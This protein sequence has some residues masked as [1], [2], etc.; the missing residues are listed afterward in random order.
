M[1]D[2]PLFQAIK[3]RLDEM[4]P[5]KRQKVIKAAIIGGIVAVVF[6]L[7]YGSGQDAKKPPPPPEVASVIELGDARLQDD[8]RAQFGKEREEQIAQNSRQDSENKELKVQ[9]AQQDAQMKAMQGILQNMSSN[10][11]LGLP[12]A[13]PLDGATGAPSADPLDWQNGELPPGA[14][15]PTGSTLGAG[16]PPVAG[17]HGGPPVP[18]TVDFIGAVGREQGVKQQPNGE[19]SKKKNRRFYLPPSFMSAKLLTGLAAKTVDNAKSDPE[20]MMLRVQAPAVLP[21]EVRAQLEGCLIV[22]HGF[23]SLASERVEAQLVSISCIDLTGK[24]MID[25]ELRG[26]VVDKDGVKGLAGHPVSKM[27]TNL[28]RLAFA[29]AVEGAGAAFSQSAQTTAIS[30]LGQTSTIDPT[31]LGRAGVGK[32]VSKASEEYGRIIADLVRQQ[33]PVIEVGP[34]KDVDVVVTEGSWLELK[35]YEEGES[36]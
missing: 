31:Q 8:I 27:G 13:N 22:A 2:N 25:A 11:G 28:A 21:N 33:S 36:P 9:L 4:E 15:L 1:A 5:E 16:A 30:P 26:I 10:P 35:S 3:K 32:G 23:G 19:G 6:V 34:A 12:G 7:Y 14:P 18:P 24:S 20:P 29:G 17:A